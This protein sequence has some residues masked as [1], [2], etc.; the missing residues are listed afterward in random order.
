MEEYN[1]LQKQNTPANQWKQEKQVLSK[2]ACKAQQVKENIVQY[3]QTTGKGKQ[4]METHRHRHSKKDE[5]T[6]EKDIR[7]RK[8]IEKHNTQMKRTSGNENT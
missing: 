2:A 5:H 1:N 3:V 4:A 6:N 7:Q 8:H